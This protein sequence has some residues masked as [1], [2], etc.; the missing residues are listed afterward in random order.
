MI[1]GYSIASIS[2]NIALLI[3]EGMAQKQA[4]AAAYSKARTLFKKKHPR[5]TLPAYLKPKSNQTMKKKVTKK[6]TVKK[7]RS[8]AQIAAT[9]KMLAAN[10]KKRGTVRKTNPVRKK[11]RTVRHHV[12]AVIPSE[13]GKKHGLDPKTIGY[14]TGTGW[15]NLKTKA[16]KYP[17][18]QA[19]RNE[20]HHMPKK[21]RPNRYYAFATETA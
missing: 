5:K 16:V 12:L 20:A 6:R 15:D 18:L 10:R 4:V 1:N 11:T 14:W 2:D 9:K 17:S 13:M 8:A 21:Y 7:K 19:A 3:R